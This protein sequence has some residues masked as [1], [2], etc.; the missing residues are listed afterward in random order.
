M[1]DL[2]YIDYDKALLKNSKILIVEDDRTQRLL[3]K[4]IFEDFGFK[5]VEEAENGDQGWKKTLKLDPDLVILDMNMPIMDGFAY[6]KKAREHPDYKNTIILVQTGLTDLEDKAAIFKV[7]ATDYVTKPLDFHE[8][9]ARSFIHLKNASNLKELNTFNARVKH[10]LLAAHNLIEISLPDDRSIKQIKSDY[11]VDIAAKF[12]STQEMGGDFWGFHP[13]SK[14]Q[15]AIYAID[16]SGHGIDSALSALRIHTLIH[17]NADQFKEPGDALEWLNKKLF[18]LFPTG[19]FSTM[20]YGIID[21]ENDALMYAVA[22]TTSPIIMY[23]D[24]KSPKIIPGNGFPLG[25]I[26]D[27]TFGTNCVGFKPSDTLVL[28]SDA[29]I[30]AMDSKGE[31][32]GDKRFVE[33]L[34][35]SFGKKSK[36]T[37][38]NALNEML[39][40]FYKECGDKLDDDLTVNFYH[41]LPLK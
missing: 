21:V 27:A 26:E 7:G 4:S 8:I 31:M 14:S 30:E 23:A 24:Q 29:I 34:K 6:C 40:A 36:F 10:E 5:H 35:E 19:Q 1:E 32:F 25:A 18:K 13:L 39:K 38:S 22:S 20:F 17:S 3:L 12:E 16:V 37:S 11:K 9:A 2:E 15:I 33:L 28:Y 41:R